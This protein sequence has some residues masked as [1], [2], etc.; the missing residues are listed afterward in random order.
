L[1]ATIVEVDVQIT[2]DGDL[3]VIHDSTLDRTTNG[4]GL[5]SSYTM[6]ELKQFDAAYHWKEYKGELIL[7]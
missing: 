3:A 6:E 2:K 7:K 1:G 5:V 4:K